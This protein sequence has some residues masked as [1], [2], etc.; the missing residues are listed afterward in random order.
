MFNAIVVKGNA[1]G[2]AMFYG[3]GA[4][5]LPTAS[6]VV[7]DVIDIAKH[8]DF[9]TMNVWVRNQANNI[10]ALEDSSAKFLVRAKVSNISEAKKNISSILGQNINFVELN[11]KTQDNELAFITKIATEKELNS[12][13]AR[14]KESGLIIEVA[15]IIRIEEE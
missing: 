11:S 4:G 6:A 8:P 9:G 13:I 7:A 2:D 1:I 14:L 3:R 5:K 12:D 10:I 15:N